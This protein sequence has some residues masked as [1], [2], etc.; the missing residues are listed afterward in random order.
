MGPSEGRLRFKLLSLSPLILFFLLFIFHVTL[1]IGA[2][3]ISVDKV[4]V[5]SDRTDAITPTYIGFHLVHTSDNSP[6][7]GAEVYVTGSSAQWYTNQQ[8]WAIVP[9]FSNTVGKK[10]WS[11]IN[12]FVGSIEVEFE[13]SV[14]DPEIIFDRVIVELETPSPRIGVGSSAQID[15][16]AKYEYD[17]TPFQG[18]VI[19]NENL[20]HD[21]VEKI[22][23]TVESISD[24]LY[25]ITVFESTSVDV[26]F[27]KV[28]IFIAASDVRIDVGSDV[29]IFEQ[30]AQYLY[31]QR[32]FTGSFTLNDT[33]SKNMVGKYTYAVNSISDIIY[34]VDSFVSNNVD[35]I[36]DEVVIDL[37]TDDSRID[38]G[39]RANITI[40]GR[41]AYDKNEFWGQIILNN[42]DKKSN[43]VGR[44]E[45][46][47][48]EIDDYKYGLTRFSSNTLDIIWDRI[49]IQL[50][51]EHERINIGEEATITWTGYY[52]YDSS[53]ANEIVEISLNS[54][55]FHRD[56]VESIEYEVI[57]VEDP[58]YGLSSYSTN[59]LKVIWDSVDVTLEFSENR[60]GISTRA[61]PRIHAT[62]RYDGS[63]FDGK[64]TL[65]NSLV[66]DFIGKKCFKVSSITDEIHQVTSFESNTE[67]CIWDIVDISLKFPKE[68]IGVG[69]EASLQINATYEFDGAPFTGKIN[70]NDSLSQNEIG[71]HSFTVSSIND[72]QFDVTSFKSNIASCIWDEIIVEEPEVTDKIGAATLEMN[73][74]YKTDGSLV[75]ETSLVLMKNVQKNELGD[76][77]K[78][79][80]STWA[81]MIKF[82]SVTNV[83]GF[84]LEHHFYTHICT[85][86]VLMYVSSSSILI[87]SSVIVITKR[88]KLRK[89]E[90]H[91]LEK[92]NSEGVINFSHFSDQYLVPISRIQEIL[93]KNSKIG[94]T[95]GIM[96]YDELGFISEQKIRST[97][98]DYEQP[99]DEIIEF[100]GE[101]KKPE[102]KEI[103][104]ENL[105]TV[106]KYRIINVTELFEISHTHLAELSPQ[107]WEIPKDYNWMDNITKSTTDSDCPE[108]SGIGWIVEAPLVRTR[109]DRHVHTISKCE[110]CGYFGF[111]PTST[112]LLPPLHFKRKME[113]IS[114]YQFKTMRKF[115][116]IQIIEKDFDTGRKILEHTP[117]TILDF[118][119]S[120]DKELVILL[121]PTLFTELDEMS[122]EYKHGVYIP[123]RERNEQD[124]QN[125]HKTQE[126]RIELIERARSLE[127]QKLIEEMKKR[128]KREILSSRDR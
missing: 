96:T 101:I 30:S 41:Y 10:T 33:N 116:E 91:I 24:D 83:P 106:E 57:A 65:N 50:E 49:H 125:H 114:I 29:D 110:K 105:K 97:V 94:N 39:S 12:V 43:T 23:Y 16:T 38:V 80:I 32:K 59:P 119:P 68:R 69:N 66:H 48:I 81:L 117:T 26:I 42:V 15:Y 34:D 75:D 27:D 60:I 25:G 71:E 124:Q 6:L 86:N 3:Q 77:Q 20:R 9:V 13:Q 44:H 98:Q 14:S 47:V 18:D 37:N 112:H 120:F 1:V 84:P 100:Y 128:R 17:G 127:A 56:A 104:F 52:E 90:F 93:S 85:N 87:I 54:E 45:Y 115:N 63:K 11:I 76:P 62:Y 107:Q 74:F 103:K 46:E 108:C 28:V 5:A 102:I 7:I 95:P 22:T 99:F 82:E 21:S 88:T 4:Y 40:E 8:G 126:G 61:D 58:L 113:R 67:Y 89:I 78:Y 55:E 35:I 64:Y 70:L 36:F 92:L 118:D 121:A 123:K 53:S 122:G 51:T 72:N 79:I 2:P 31:D 109:K 111:K 73:I 19:I